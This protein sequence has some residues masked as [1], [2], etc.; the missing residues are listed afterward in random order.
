MN[1]I[2]IFTSDNGGLF[3]TVHDGSRRSRLLLMVIAP[4]FMIHPLAIPMHLCILYALLFSASAVAAPASDFPRAVV[5]I[6]ADDLGYGDLSCYG[7]TRIH[8]PRIDSLAAHGIRFT[9]A[10]SP[11]AVC[12]P[13]RYAL[14]TG[15]YCWRTSLKRRVLAP[16][17]PLHIE[18]GRETLASFLKK[19]GYATGIIGKWHLGLGRP[20]ETDWNTEPIAPGP[21]DVGFGFSHI[22]SGSNNFPP[23]VYIENGRV[24]D[25]NDGETIELDFPPTGK[26]TPWW[27]LVEKRTI[28]KKWVAEDMGLHLAREAVEF[29]D[30]HARQPF[31]LYFPAPNPHLPLTPNKKF[32]GTSKAGAYGDFVQELDFMTGMILDALAR[33]GLADDALV[34]FTSDN[35][36]NIHPSKRTGHRANGSLR[37]SKGEV[38]EGGHRVPFIVRWPARAAAGKVSDSPI[39]Q[40]D[41]LASLHALFGEPVPPGTA[42]DSVNVL[43]ALLDEETHPKDRIMIHHASNGVFAIRRGDWKL[44][45]G[46]PAPDNRPDRPVRLQRKRPA[47]NPQLFNLA[48]D[49]KEMV[50]VAKDHPELVADLLKQLNAVR[51]NGS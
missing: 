19:N 24:V 32:Q 11:A 34:I 5:L 9:D 16:Q 4:R 22:I 45:E 27:K 36:G 37:G 48:K 43:A 23:S 8:T 30:A 40:V 3:R 12:S 14:L 26:G 28:S 29:I 33:N 21:N 46:I 15:R 38:Y 18:T 10:H 44:I 6:Y 41:L 42:P 49:P 50:N 20:P 51:D 25:R 13:S 39:S 7:A 1:T 35:G 2:V 17:A 31:F 47:A